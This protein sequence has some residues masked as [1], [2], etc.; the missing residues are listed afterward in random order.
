MTRMILILLLTFFINGTT[1]GVAW[2]ALGE[3]ETSIDSDRQTLQGNRNSTAV[4][5]QRAGYRVHEIDYDSTHVREYVSLD[6]T[7]FAVSWRGYS[8]PDLSVLLGNYFQEVSDATSAARRGER[9][10]E[11][12]N[13][14]LKRYGHM[15]DVGGKAYVS[16]LVPAGVNVSELP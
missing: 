5:S 14:T 9:T 15:R 7:V 1:R 11:T 2:A 10:I 12:Q 6:G 13:V 4:T 3:R 8:R 16:D